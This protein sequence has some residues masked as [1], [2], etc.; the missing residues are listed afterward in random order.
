MLLIT[1]R[2]PI[3]SA[4][5]I[6]LIR[7]PIEHLVSIF[8][9]KKY[10]D[11]TETGYVKDTFGKCNIVSKNHLIRMSSS[12]PCQFSCFVLIRE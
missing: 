12:V 5:V 9:M 3:K 4:I 1:S 6:N 8:K 11:R 7:E 10:G 2:K